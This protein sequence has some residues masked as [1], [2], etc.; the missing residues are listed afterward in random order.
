MIVV[1]LRAEDCFKKK[2]TEQW[3]KEH[4]IC[5]LLMIEQTLI[6][7]AYAWPTKANKTLDKDLQSLPTQTARHVSGRSRLKHNPAELRELSARVTDPSGPVL[8]SCSH[9]MK[10]HLRVT[11]DEEK[12]VPLLCEWVLI[13]HGF[14]DRTLHPAHPLAKKSLKQLLRDPHEHSQTCFLYFR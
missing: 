14:R 11:S 12:L 1:A 2:S 6:S 3:Q 4:S 9:N 7:L 10:K 13:D 5:T 8:P